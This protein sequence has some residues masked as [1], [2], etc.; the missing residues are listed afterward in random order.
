MR[1]ELHCHTKHS[2]TVAPLDCK[3]EPVEVVRQAK[4]SGLAGIAITDHDT[5]AAWKAAKAEAKKQGV[6]F[7][8]GIEISSKR[9]H[10]LGLG[11][12]EAI[13]AKHSVGETIDR[14]HDAGG[15]AI[16]AHPF[17]IRGH[18]VKE[19]LSKA[20]AVETFNALSV[21]RFSNMLTES[22]AGA[23]G[24]PQ[25]SGSDA[26]TLG[27]IGR[28]A[29]EAR[30][31]DLD[32]VIREIRKGRVGL[33]KRYVY[34]NEIKE[35]SR[36]RMIEAYIDVVEYIDSRYGRYR[37]WMLKHLMKRFILSRNPMWDVVARASLVGAI[38]YSLL[39]AAAYY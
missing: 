39:K 32:S 2:T 19:L 7:I 4:R 11:V 15:I 27:M 30:A 24:M 14:I 18:G 16:A 38:S 33:C 6:V 25:T 17:D 13:G 21:D 10:I 29:I 20:D 22:K 31:H 23:L 12:S 5:T 37:A 26:H 34:L 35:W 1:F 3:E 28:A 8:P 36:L 9:G